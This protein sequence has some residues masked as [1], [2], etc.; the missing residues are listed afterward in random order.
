[1]KGLIYRDLIAF[2]RR[3]SKVSWIM[4]FVFLLF[5]LLAI[6]GPAAVPT[7]LL[8]VQPINISG[9]ASTLKELDTNYAGRFSL[10]LPVSHS[11]QVLSRFISSYLLLLFHLPEHILFVLLHYAVRGQYT[12]SSYLFYLA[13]GLLI[14]FILTAI[15]ITSTF[16]MGINGNAIFYLL[17]IVVMLLIYASHWFLDLDFTALLQMTPAQLLL[18][19][20]VV[21]VLCM[22]AGYITSKKLY[23]KKLN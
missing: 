22:N 23:L 3:T 16:M 15:N 13:A 20:M 8:L 5:F 9:A 6:K 4:D 10:T 11:Q 2:F 17:T 12:M 1:M 7:Y 18:S 21:A 14:A 19:A